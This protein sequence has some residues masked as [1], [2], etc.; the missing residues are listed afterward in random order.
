MS[1][2][3]MTL[4]VST[5]SIER[6]EVSSRG[7]WK[8]VPALKR[9][10]ETIVAKG[11]WI[12]I[13]SLLDEDWVERELRKPEECIGVLKA[14]SREFKA[15]ILRFS[16]MVPDTLPRYDFPLEMRSLAVAEVGDFKRWWEGLPQE[17]RKN[18]RRSQK[19]GV[20]IEIK[21]FGPEVIAGIAGVQNETPVR[22]GRRYPHY[23]KSLEQVR[24]DH[25]AFQDRSTFLCAYFEQEMIGFL[26]LVYRGRVASLLQLNSKV[27]H[28]DKRPSNALM[29]KA[30]ELCAE[31]GVHYLTYGLF[32]YGAKGHSPLRE[33]KE[34]NGFREMLI[35][36]YYV[37]LTSWGDICVRFKLYRGIQEMIPKKM[38]A[39]ALN[40]RARWYTLH[41]SKAGVAQ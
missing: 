17:S 34:R 24:R 15:D 21:E 23:G 12:R 10:G 27:A 1:N 3:S 9:D 11:Q 18:V 30:A 22:Q 39:T 20:R 19:R 29:A 26:K 7:L 33:F 38:M 37:P 6:V 35:P 40:L 25:G 31:R 13:A 16:Q 4:P 36:S 41:T 5:V 28:H 32:N 2:P 8:E 14:H